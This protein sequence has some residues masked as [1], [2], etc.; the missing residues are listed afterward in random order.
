[1]KSFISTITNGFTPLPEKSRFFAMK[2]LLRKTEACFGGFEIP[3]PYQTLD[4]IFCYRFK[5]RW[6]LIER[7]PGILKFSLSGVPIREEVELRQR[8]PEKS[9][10]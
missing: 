7:S 4:D 10:I 8:F 6:I 5:R 2:E 3:R 9:L 1:M